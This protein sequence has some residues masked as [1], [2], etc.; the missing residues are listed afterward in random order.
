V[1]CAIGLAMPSSGQGDTTSG[2]VPPLLIVKTDKTMQQALADLKQGIAD[3]NYV[4]IRQQNL[5]SRL[6]N[7]PAENKQV[8]LVYFC[9]FSMLNRAL[10]TDNRVGVFLPCKITLVKRNDHVE[11][12]AVNPK[13]ISKKLN[14][15]KLNAICNKLT[16][17]YRLI[18]EDATV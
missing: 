4:F 18:L 17:D 5:D 10:R 11:M 9:N 12:I 1:A 15:E 6:T 14:E 8:I 3:N 7:E 13:M 2:P 16:Q